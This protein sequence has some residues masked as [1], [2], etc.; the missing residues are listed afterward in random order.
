MQRTT[1]S[2]VTELLRGFDLPRARYVDH[3]AQVGNLPE[4]QALFSSAS[5]GEYPFN[6]YS[7]DELIALHR[8]RNTFRDVAPAAV[9]IAPFRTRSLRRGVT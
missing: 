2:L 6:P 1:V 4:G 7:W 5:P 8:T 3:N 9:R